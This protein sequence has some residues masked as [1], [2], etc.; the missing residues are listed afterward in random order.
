MSVI[1]TLTDDKLESMLNEI[2]FS[3]KPEKVQKIRKDLRE[4]EHYGK[5]IYATVL[6]LSKTLDKFPN[7][8]DWDSDELNNIFILLSRI[9]L[10]IGVR[11]AR[12]EEEMKKTTDGTLEQ[13]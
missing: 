7:P 1:D 10:E 4:I 5:N 9:S 6:T 12:I 13:N 8:K 11:A 2:R 3:F